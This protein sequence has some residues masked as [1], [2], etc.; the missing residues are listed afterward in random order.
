MEAVVRGTGIPK[1]EFLHVDDLADAALFLMLNYD[2]EEIINVGTGEDL[3]I[4]DLCGIIREVVGYSGRIFYDGSMPD[5]TPRKVLDVTR[6]TALGWAPKIPLRSG[7]EQTYRW[8][9]SHYN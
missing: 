2:R 3:T 5:G 4:A 8:Y 6:L 7:I 9:R 1:R